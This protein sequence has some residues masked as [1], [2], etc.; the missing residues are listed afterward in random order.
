MHHYI[1]KIVTDTGRYVL[2]VVAHSTYAAMLIATMQL[3][4]H[5]AMCIRS[6]SGVAQ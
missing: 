2:D 6:I 1:V 4:N 5:E 3:P